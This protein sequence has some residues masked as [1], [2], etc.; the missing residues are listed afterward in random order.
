M[1]LFT[2][3]LPFPPPPLHTR[4]R[5]QISRVLF[6]ADPIGLGVVTSTAMDV[7]LSDEPYHGYSRSEPFVPKEHPAV[8]PGTVYRR[9]DKDGEG[10]EGGLSIA[11]NCIP[12]AVVRSANTIPLSWIRFSLLFDGS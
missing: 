11:S 7:I 6:S 12:R 10:G 1:G 9:R 2:A 8:E 4:G 3:L 5:H